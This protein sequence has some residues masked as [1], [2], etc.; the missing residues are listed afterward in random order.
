MTAQPDIQQRR[1]QVHS[2]AAFGYSLTEISEQL[3]AKDILNPRTGKPYSTTTIRADLMARQPVTEMIGRAGYAVE[4]LWRATGF[5]Y[6]K[7]RPDYQFW[8]RFRH[9]KAEGFELAGGIAH[10]NSATLTSFV[11]GDRI[12]VS[13]VKDGD[14]NNENDPRT[15]TAKLA[16]AIVAREA[17]T[18]ARVVKDQY[19]LGD[20]FVIVNPD[21]SW[22]IPSPDTVEVEHDPLDYRKVVKYKVTTR[23]KDVTIV[24]EFTAER[25]TQTVKW[26]NKGG[27]S[28]EETRTFANLI[29]KIPV[30]HLAHD[31]SANELFGRSIHERG[32]RVYSRFDDLLEK[33]SD[34]VE[35]LGNPIPAIEG[36]ENVQATLELLKTLTDET[37]TDADGSDDTR[38]LIKLDRLPMFIVGKGG[39]VTFVAP[40]KGFTADSM[41]T[42]YRYWLLAGEFEGLPEWVRGNA[43]EASKAST[44]TQLPP[45]IQH[46]K[47]LRLQLEGQGYDPLLDAEPNG[48]LHELL[49][50]TLLTRKLTDPKIVIDAMYFTFPEVSLESE[51]TLTQRVIYAKGINLIRDSTALKMLRLVPDADQ[52]VQLAEAEAP[53]MDDFMTQLNAAAHQQTDPTRP[54][55][56]RPNRNPVAPPDPDGGKQVRGV[57]DRVREM[58]AAEDAP[59]AA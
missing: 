49:Y 17:A 25:R 27:K 59:I 43:I 37:Y 24:D 16:N 7:T 50:L 20:Q 38:K 14:P 29:G 23:L 36:V 26:H 19:D 22:S 1:K 56:N 32:L 2:L 52:E 34:G 15:Y 51:N 12:T 11:L 9:G 42:L 6:D 44:E 39:K 31:R 35:L 48:G 45:F 30:V 5:S 58:E 40:E 47:M 55:S 28:T 21:G 53:K 3:A 57:N 4:P 13:L 46:I 33:T 10:R 18:L 41:G 54:T 8:D